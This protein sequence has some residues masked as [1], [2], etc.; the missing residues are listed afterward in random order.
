MS[1]YLCAFLL[2][3]C[4]SDSTCVREC[5]LGYYPEGK[6][7]RVCEQCHFSCQSCVG[8]HSVQCLT[9]QPGFFKQGKSCVETCPESHFGNTATMVCEHCDPSCR[10][11][12]G[13]GN[14]NCLS[15]RGG[16]VYLR[17]R[18][19][20]LQSCPPN[21]YEDT[22]SKSCHMCHPTCKTC[23]GNGILASVHLAVLYVCCFCPFFGRFFLF[24]MFISEHLCTVEALVLLQASESKSD[25]PNCR[26]CDSSC[27][28]CRGPGQWNCTVCPATRI[29]SD[30]G[31][32]LSCCGIEA[33]RN[34]PIPWECC[35]CNASEGKFS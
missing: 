26:P 22:W 9:C 31:R 33:H 1:R 29:L 3:L 14:R 18:G 10:R 27:V 2:Y 34:K 13:Q 11:C 7:E 6:D 35:D 8:P 15:C 16:Y 24:N 25:E 12:A 5:P 32:C 17:Q 28:D 21:Y 23:S 30:D 19:Q 4:S 20:C